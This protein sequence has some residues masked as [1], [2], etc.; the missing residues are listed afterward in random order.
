MFLLPLILFFSPL[1]RGFE[2]GCQVHKKP[3]FKVACEHLLALSYKCIFCIHKHATL[4]S[5][6]TNIVDKL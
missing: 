4:L 3:A 1:L 5:S 6:Y 2:L